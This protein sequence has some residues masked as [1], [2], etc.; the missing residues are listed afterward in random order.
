MLLIP[1]L[2]GAVCAGQEAINAIEVKLDLLDTYHWYNPSGGGEP[3]LWLPKLFWELDSGIAELSVRHRVTQSI[4][5]GMEAK[6]DAL[7]LGGLGASIE[8]LEMKL[9]TQELK[10]DELPTFIFDS[11]TSQNLWLQDNIASQLLSLS[12]Y[13]DNSHDAVVQAVQAYIDPIAAKLEDPSS[14]LVSIAGAVGSIETKLDDPSIGLGSIA[15]SLGEIWE[16]VSEEVIIPIYDYSWVSSQS[17]VDALEA[18]LDDP[19]TGLAYIASQVGHVVPHVEPDL[20]WVAT[21][22]SV[23]AMEAKLDDQTSGLDYIASV[24]DVIEG[25]VS[26]PVI[27]DIVDDTWIAS[28]ASV[29]AIEAKLDD[30][31]SGLDEIHAQIAALTSAIE[32]LE[33]K[34]D[35]LAAP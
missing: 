4:L 20:S 8:A 2:V 17:S 16:Q 34:V 3:Q 35:D 26:V 13:L 9:D 10:L 22:T 31:T 15:A 18:K 6:I 33:A 28:Q 23:D 27:D 1:V 30:P 11:L 24:V 14:G 29:D 12:V 32:A 25:Y 19:N 21:Q 5:D 7:G